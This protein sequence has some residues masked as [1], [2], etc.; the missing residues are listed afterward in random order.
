M[1]SCAILK[2]C[3]LSSDLVIGETSLLSPD[4]GLN[5]WLPVG[6]DS[7]APRSRALPLAVL[8]DGY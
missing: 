8:F 5:V 6:R 2:A 7:S 3:S 4:R 1:G